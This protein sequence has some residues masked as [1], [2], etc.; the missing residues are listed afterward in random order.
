MFVWVHTWV[1]DKLPEVSWRT[2][3]RFQGVTLG[4]TPSL[5]TSTATASRLGIWCVCMCLCACVFAA[6]PTAGKRSMRPPP[7]GSWPPA[8][9]VWEW[10]AVG[11]C[12]CR[13]KKWVSSRGM[14][15][16]NERWGGREGGWG[17]DRICPGWLTHSLLIFLP[18]SQ[19]H[20]CSLPWVHTSVHT[21]THTRTQEHTSLL[22][23]PSASVP[24]LIC[25]GGP[26]GSLGPY[27]PSHTHTD[28][29]TQWH[30]EELMCKTCSDLACWWWKT[31]SRAPVLV[32]EG[33]T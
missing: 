28:T 24:L 3:G 8:A 20:I 31:G 14:R 17:R 10:E 7:T 25:A 29:L 19:M 33:K 6:A 9:T 11:V 2:P 18:Y 32:P 23:L 26:A 15:E 27:V 21:H 12:V 22:S 13:W 4:R 1:L 16:Q 30:T 5:P